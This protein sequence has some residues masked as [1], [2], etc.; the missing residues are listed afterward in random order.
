MEEELRRIQDYINYGHIGDKDGSEDS[1]SISSDEIVD[2]ARYKN[3]LP[4]QHPLDNWVEWLVEQEGPQRRKGDKHITWVEEDKS[5]ESSSSNLEE[6]TEYQWE[7]LKEWHFWSCV[8]KYKSVLKKI[9]PVNKATPQS[10]N[11]LLVRPPLTR[12]PYKTPIT[13]NPPEFKATSKVTEERLKMINFGPEGWL[14]EEELQL[15]KHIIVLREKA[16]AFC[17]EERGLLKTSYGLPYI[18]PVGGA[19]RTKFKQKKFSLPCSNLFRILEFSEVV[20]ELFDRLY[21]DK[22][23]DSL[24]RNQSNE[25]AGFL[26]V[27]SWIRSGCS[28][29]NKMFKQPVLRRIDL[30]SMFL[31]RLCRLLV[32]DLN[33]I[34]D[35]LHQTII[36]STNVAGSDNPGS[37]G[38][39]EA[40]VL[41]LY[42]SL[43]DLQKK[44]DQCNSDTLI[45]YS[46]P[47]FLLINHQPSKKSQ[48]SLTIN[49]RLRQHQQL[50][51]SHQL[52]RQ[53]SQ[54]NFLSGSKSEGMINY[55]PVLTQDEKLNLT[56]CDNNS[57]VRPSDNKHNNTTIKSKIR[58]R[59]EEP[60]PSNQTTDPESIDNQSEFTA[61][62]ILSSQQMTVVNL[63]SNLQNSSSSSL[64]F[65]LRLQLSP[66]TRS[67]LT[68][69]SKS[70]NTTKPT[71]IRPHTP[72]LTNKNWGGGGP[73]ELSYGLP[74]PPSPIS[75]F[76]INLS[77]QDVPCTINPRFES[78]V[79][80]DPKPLTNYDLPQ[81]TLTIQALP[82]SEHPES[83]RSNTPGQS[84]PENL[85]N[86]QLSSKLEIEHKDEDSEEEDTD[87]DF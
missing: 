41:E 12:N 62:S 43:M 66:T 44:H 23:Q 30:V 9:K 58:N 83:N 8:A 59:S 11:P 55:S 86:H 65:S 29:L 26:Q 75:A 54:Q 40:D 15:M 2:I 5:G 50:I 77:T 4:E 82:P 64:P 22:S 51:K 69:K 10:L 37:S 87:D 27:I 76:E 68:P 60:Q 49:N 79:T 78:G 36:S 32:L 38:F 67:R 25:I 53:H 13:P 39:D 31:Y 45:A 63:Q 20:T 14:L 3:L 33:M 42:S 85:P 81:R 48:N 28:R 18:I 7:N 57:S 46:N 80:V 21:S 6:D 56:A 61:V 73:S 72:D 24:L 34:T 52:N 71:A 47:R 35:R 1:T 17:K 74:D 84:W 19:A 16:I 70:T